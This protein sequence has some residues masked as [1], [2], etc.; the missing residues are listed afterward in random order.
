MI[1]NECYNID[2]KKVLPITTVRLIIYLVK[3]TVQ[4]PGWGGY[5]F[6]VLLPLEPIAYPRPNEVKQRLSTAIKVSTVSISEVL[7][8]SDF[9]NE[10]ISM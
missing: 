2:N 1:R 7:L 5:F 8:P 9:S 3:I 6:V 10:S 4:F